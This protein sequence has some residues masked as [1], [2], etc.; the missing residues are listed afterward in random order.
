MAKSQIS[1][2]KIYLIHYYTKILFSKFGT[3]PFCSI[4]LEIS[5]NWHTKSQGH[6]KKCIH[7]TKGMIHPFP[8]HTA[9][10]WG[11]FAPYNTE[12]MRKDF[13]NPTVW[14]LEILSPILSLFIFF[15]KKLEQKT[16]Y[17]SHSIAENT[18]RNI[19][20]L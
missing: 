8:A 2:R 17:L 11:S 4:W 14:S 3:S 6:K 10:Y 9:C 13:W 15:F 19:K 1:E 16:S 12:A 18:A 7:F 20:R 5:T